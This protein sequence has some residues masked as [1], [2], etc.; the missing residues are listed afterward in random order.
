MGL[1]FMENGD[2]LKIPKNFWPP[3]PNLKITLYQRLDRTP[4]LSHRPIFP[5]ER[6]GH[7]TDQ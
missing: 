1:K 2:R 7:L 3:G 6:V 4:F 5:G